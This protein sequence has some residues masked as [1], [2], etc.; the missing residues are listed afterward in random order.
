MDQAHFWYNTVL[1]EFGYLQKQGHFSSGTLSQTLDI[2]EF[3]HNT[4]KNFTTVYHMQITCTSLQTDNHA[5]TSSLNFL[6]AGCFSWCP[7]NSVKALKVRWMIFQKYAKTHFICTSCLLSAGGAFC[8]FWL[9]MLTVARYWTSE[10]RCFQ[11]T[12]VLVLSMCQVWRKLARLWHTSIGRKLAINEYTLH[13]QEV[14]RAPQCPWTV[15]SKSTSHAVCVCY[16]KSKGTSRP[17][18][19]SA[20]LQLVS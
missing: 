7:A 3:H 19:I 17:S 8:L 4:L 20:D 1:R 9:P 11:T 10:C 15:S 5:S 12:Q 14:A 2:E 13:L 18:E 16:R 6:Q